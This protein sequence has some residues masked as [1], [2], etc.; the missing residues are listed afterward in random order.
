M[1]PWDGPAALFFTN[2]KQ[3]GATLDRNGLRP[4]RYCIT[5]DHRLIMA[6]EAG[7]IVTDESKIIKKGRLQ[8]GKMLLADL[9][10]GVIYDD[11]QIKALVC[12]DKPYKKWLEE[13]RI[14]LRLMPIPEL[15]AKIIEPHRLT[16]R[17]MSNGMTEE[18]VKITILP[19]ARTGTEPLGSMGS[20]VPLAVL[21]KQSQHISN[22]FKQYFAQVSNSSHRSH[23]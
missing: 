15:Q 10:L 23:S 20:D 5:S 4:A 16:T 1:E 21:S 2:G 9:S 6:S 11:S 19:F 13:Q 3:I 22:Y 18:D 17:Q 14:K 12:D 8:P 7:A